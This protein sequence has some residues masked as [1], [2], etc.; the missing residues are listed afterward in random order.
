MLYYLK[1]FVTFI[2]SIMMVKNDYNFFHKDFKPLRVAGWI[3]S[4]FVLSYSV[5]ITDA[6]YSYAAKIRE[7]CP[8]CN[9]RIKNAKTEKKADRVAENK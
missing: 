9:D 7:V 1:M 6:F 3:I 8:D 2:L 5:Y 4:A